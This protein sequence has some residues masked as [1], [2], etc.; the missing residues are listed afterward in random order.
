[1]PVKSKKTEKPEKKA[2]PKKTSKK[3]IYTVGRRKKASARVRLH[4]K[5]KGEI[6][7]N[8]APIEK[9]FPGEIEKSLY[10]SPLRT[11]NVIGK[12]LITVKVTGSGKSGQLGAV[13]HGIAR[14]LTKLDREK[15]YPILKKRGFLTRDP[16]MKER[17]KT[18]TGGKARRRKQSP[19]R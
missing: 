13:I 11:C 1:M 8:G 5:K 17:R 9:Y 4:L 10:L 19:K 15:F 16:R 18:G 6:E 14:A 2:K 3:Y 7:V 12:Y